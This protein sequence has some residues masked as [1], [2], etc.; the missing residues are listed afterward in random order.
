[1]IRRYRRPAESAPCRSE[2]R[3]QSRF[4]RTGHPCW[5]PAWRWWIWRS[6][7]PTRT[8]SLSCSWSAW[9]WPRR[10]RRCHRH[11]PG[12]RS[13]TSSVAMIS[14]SWPPTTASPGS[15]AA[16]GQRS[17]NALEW[18]EVPGCRPVRAKPV[19]TV[20]EDRCPTRVPC[21][22]RRW[23]RCCRLPQPPPPRPAGPPLR[24]RTGCPRLSWLPRWSRSCWAVS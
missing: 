10:D 18:L 14:L 2:P 24:R 12:R 8:S 5:R 11:A 22:A 16:A 21:L 9:S 17:A 7:L 3:G 19:R 20:G 13:P 15:L 23:S 6:T 1:M 4:K